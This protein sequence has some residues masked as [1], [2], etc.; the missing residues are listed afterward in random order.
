[1]NFLFRKRS[2]GKVKQNES[3][4]ILPELAAVIPDHTQDEVAVVIAL[5]IHMYIN[6][7]RECENTSIT[8]QR[9]I[10]PYSPWSSKI[11]GLRQQPMYIP[12]LKS[13]LK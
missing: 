13:R 11:Y 1:M 9:A 6:Q 5:A 10:K 8:M 4:V 7:M 3:V 2:N 12:G